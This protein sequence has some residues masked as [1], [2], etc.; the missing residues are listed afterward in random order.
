MKQTKGRTIAGM[1]VG[2]GLLTYALLKIVAPYRHQ[3][4]QLNGLV[5]VTAVF[6]DTDAAATTSDAPTTVA[7]AAAVATPRPAETAG[8][9]AA[10]T[11]ATAPPPEPDKRQVA[12]TAPAPLPAS[13]VSVAP[14]PPQQTPSPPAASPAA[15]VK[16]ADKAATARSERSVRKTV[17]EAVAAAE[18][19]TSRPAPPAS[20]P[21]IVSTAWW[22]TSAPSGGFQ[23]LYV[24][25]AAFRLAIV[26]LTNAR[27][28]DADSANRHVA[29]LDANGQRVAG[30]WELGSANPSMLVFPITTPGRYE[31][32]IGG[33]FADPQNRQIGETLRGGVRVP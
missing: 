15:T 20:A 25:S 21:P 9:S 11:P 22:Q 6:D 5:P 32:V 4:I 2:V 10:A 28:A 12:P 23:L 16:S 27:P 33:G 3:E 19:P 14:A 30:S 1:A 7:T 18:R 13:P 26:M 8:V 17:K 24:G 31:V 29:V